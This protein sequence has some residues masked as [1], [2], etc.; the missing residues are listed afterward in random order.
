MAFLN[1]NLRVG[2]NNTLPSKVIFL[3]SLIEGIDMGGG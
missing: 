1:V 2:F 3:S